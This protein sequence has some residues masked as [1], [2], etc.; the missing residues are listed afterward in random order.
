MM[1]LVKKYEISDFET[2]L[3]LLMYLSLKQ[4]P[5]QKENKTIS[6]SYDL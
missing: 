6:L 4:I 1:K 3:Y 5:P 2:V